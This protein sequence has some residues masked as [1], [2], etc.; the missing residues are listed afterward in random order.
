MAATFIDTVDLRDGILAAS[1]AGR[2]KI[3]DSFF[4]V[5]TVDNKFASNVIKPAKLKYTSETWD[6]SGATALR[7]PTPTGASD[8]ATKGYTDS[9]AAGLDVKASVRA[10]TTAALPAVTAAGSGVGKT[11]TA[12]AVG[13]LTV[14]GVTTV[15]DDRLLVKN[16]ATASNNGI[17]KVTTEGNPGTAFVLTRATDADENSE[18]TPGLFTFVEEGTVNADKGYVLASDA[19]VIVDATS[20]SF[21]QFSA[22]GGGVTYVAGA[23]MTE[24]GGGTNTFDVVSG[25]SAIVANANDITLT[26]NATNP[27]LVIST[28][29][30][31]KNDVTTST[32]GNIIRGANGITTDT[33]GSTIETASFKLQLKDAG[34]TF[35]KLATAVS[36]RLGGY[37]RREDFVGDGSTVAFVLAVS[38]AKTTSGGNLVTQGGLVRKSGGGNDY[39]ISGT[40]VTFITAPPNNANISVFYKR[41]GNAI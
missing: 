28:G 7:A 16:Q 1:S 36:D 23:G 3:A 25:N 24:S 27:G 19:P 18:V 38:D 40:T 37:D 34:T 11:L 5:T 12:D 8:V 31:V 4:D 9:L 39:T 15:L 2:A 33:D 41:T 22:A 26:L 14:D 35:A 30:L 20:L 21:S 17:Y 6:F 29:L 32:V 13:T 10:A